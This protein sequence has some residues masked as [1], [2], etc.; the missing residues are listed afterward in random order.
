M[1]TGYGKAGS[2]RRR[3]CSTRRISWS[4]NKRYDALPYLWNWNDITATTFCTIKYN[5]IFQKILSH[6]FRLKMDQD[7]CVQYLTSRVP[8]EYMF[9][10]VFVTSCKFLILARQHNQIST[11]HE[12]TAHNKLCWNSTS[13]VDTLMTFKLAQELKMATI[14]QSFDY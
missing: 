10:D 1:V 8:A 14:R 6:T 9:S 2:T 13:T 7:G 4:N 3:V 5:T 12:H 11:S